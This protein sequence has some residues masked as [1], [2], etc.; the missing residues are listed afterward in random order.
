VGK[1]SRNKGAA[2]ERE[3]ANLLKARGHDAR[4]EGQMQAG[5]GGTKGDADV[6]GL[7]PFHIESKRQERVAIEAWCLQAAADAAH[8]GKPW[9]VAWRQSRKRWK[10][11]L[12]LDAFLDL[13]ERAYGAVLNAEPDPA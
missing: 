3:L 2:G 11:A 7:P 8:T 10:V 9:V 4:R 12:D 1:A 5:W 13:Y 6:S